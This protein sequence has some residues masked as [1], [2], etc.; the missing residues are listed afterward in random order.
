MAKVGG[1]P[2]SAT[3]EFFVNANDLNAS[4]LDEQNEGFTVFGRVPDA[5]MVVVSAING[6][7]T[8]TYQVQVGF[9]SRTLESVPMNAAEAPVVMDPNLLVKV[10]SVTAAPI[11][12][13]EV[14][15]QNPGVATASISGTNITVNGVATGSTTVRVKAIDLDGTSTTQDIA[16]TV[17]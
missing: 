14:L 2:N 1:S 11:L 17:P 5:G 4:N 10:T 13:Y 6:L 3:S 9:T 12:Q 7:P 16:V 15:S 8:K